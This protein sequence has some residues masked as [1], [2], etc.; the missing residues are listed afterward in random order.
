MLAVDQ[1]RLA[2]GGLAR[3]EQQGIA[4]AADQRIEREQALE[5]QFAAA[6][7][8]LSVE[9]E[10]A[11]HECLGVPARATLVVVDEG[12]LAMRHHRPAAQH[13]VQAVM[14]SA[15]G[16]PGG[17]GGV[18]GAG[19]GAELAGGV[20]MAGLVHRHPGHAIHGESIRGGLSRGGLGGLG[21]FHRHGHAGH[22]RVGSGLGRDARDREE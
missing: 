7:R 10:M 21:L 5:G 18:A 15:V 19:I 4:V 9:H 20:V 12:G 6:E 8:M 1:P 3:L 17:A 16:L 11:Q 22:R 2:V 14:R 13:I